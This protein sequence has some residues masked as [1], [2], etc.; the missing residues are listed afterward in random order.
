[1]GWRVDDLPGKLGS[2]PQSCDAIEAYNL[3]IPSDD[4]HFRYHF[5]FVNFKLHQK[6]LKQAII[7][8]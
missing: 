8:Y 5:L 6:V 1:M 4:K 2:S 3:N 7:N